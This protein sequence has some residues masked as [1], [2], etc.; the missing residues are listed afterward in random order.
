MIY[1][2]LSVT[3]SK[4]LLST[5]FPPLNLFISIAQ[6]NLRISQNWNHKQIDIKIL[7]TIKLKLNFYDTLYFLIFNKQILKFK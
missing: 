2:G 1:G 3:V 5:I 4:Q 6:K 7:I